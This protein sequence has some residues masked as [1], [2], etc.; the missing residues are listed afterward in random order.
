MLVFGSAGDS[1]DLGCQGIKDCPVCGRHESF[2]LRLE[3]T[4]HHL[5][6]IFGKVSAKRY[7]LYCEGCGNGTS[8]PGSN[9]ERRLGKM[10]IP[11]M[12][13]HGWIVFLILLG[14]GVVYLATNA[15]VSGKWRREG[16]QRRQ[17][18]EYN[19][20]AVSKLEEGD[21]E[22]A[23]ADLNRA[24]AL[25][26]R[27]HIA[28]YNRANARLM[29]GEYEK[30]TRDLNTALGI[31]PARGYESIQADIYTSRAG[32]KT[33]MGRHEEAVADAGK[34]I[35]LDAEHSSAH[36]VRASVWM[37]MGEFDN[38]IKDFDRSE[39]LSRE[40][41]DNRG[42]LSSAI[43]RSAAKFFKGD[44]QGALADDEKAKQL[45]P[46]CTWVYSGRAMTLAKGFKQFDAAIE[47][48]NMALELNPENSS[49]YSTR[50]YAYAGL[51]NTAN[52]LTALKPC[53]WNRMRRETGTSTLLFSHWQ[54]TEVVR[55]RNS[56]N[57]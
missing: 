51:G 18:G 31:L 20:K 46:G 1:V 56:G 48:C 25:D 9:I 14:M 28:Y 22:G 30:A 44:Y 54:V 13:R 57:P 4:Y 55:W 23:I 42:V 6:F 7:L 50:G 47:S 29:T 21:I 3:Y 33:A 36:F 35:E 2:R 39:S 37:E 16:E 19:E 34:A 10:P 43:G 32:V 38:A 41:N 8:I 40:S 15:E 53:R 27:F 11:F 52:A 49:A 5:W 26:P 45:D 24:I 12:R 17:A